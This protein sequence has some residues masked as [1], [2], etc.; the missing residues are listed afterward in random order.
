MGRLFEAFVRN[1]LWREQDL[2]HVS[3]PKIDWSVDLAVS[4]DS[5]WL[6]EMRTDITL[7]SKSRRVVIEV[8]Y[9]A[10]PLQSHHGKKTLISAHLYQLLTYLSHLRADRG[11]DP[12]GVLLYGGP[13][14]GESLR[15]QL[16]ENTVLIRNLDLNR[17]WR[18]IH[19]D[20]LRMSKELAAFTAV[21]SSSV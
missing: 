20:L 12:I 8:K 17:E 2:F 21:Q 11:G 13:G 10:N 19:S 14:P 5:T 18:H 9:Y 4:S 7:T 15:Y 3:A 16:G 1:F 6:P